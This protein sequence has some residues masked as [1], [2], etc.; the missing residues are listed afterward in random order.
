[1]TPSH[2]AYFAAA[3]IALAAPHLAKAAWQPNPYYQ[4]NYHYTPVQ[5]YPV[6]SAMVPVQ[7]QGQQSVPNYGYQPQP[8]YRS[9]NQPVVVVPFNAFGSTIR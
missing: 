6:P 9:P 3:A 5:P 8:Q 1:M 4:P 2:I 7:G